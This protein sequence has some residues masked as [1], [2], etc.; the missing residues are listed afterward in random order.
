MRTTKLTLACLL[1]AIAGCECTPGDGEGDGGDGNGSSDGNGGCDGPFRTL[2]GGYCDVLDRCPTAYPIA[3]RSREEC[4]DILCWAFT[5]RL[6]D[7][8][9]NDVHHYRLEQHI[10][11]LTAP[12]AELCATWLQSAPCAVL[13][14]EAD[15]GPNPCSGLTFVADDDDDDDDNGGDIAIG[16]SCEQDNYDCVAGAYCEPGA[17]LEGQGARSCALC[18]AL[19]E[20]GDACGGYG[21]A[22]DLACVYDADA[23]SQVCIVRR[24]A[25]ASCGDGNA[26]TSGFCNFRTN[27]CDDEGLPGDA[28]TERADCRQ[29]FCDGVCRDSLKNGEPCGDQ[30]ECWSGVC[31]ETT[32]R[33]GSPDG[34]QCSYGSQ[35]ESN[36]CDDTTALCAPGAV[37]GASCDYDED[38][39]SGYCAY[40]GDYCAERCS[41]DADCADGERCND[42]P[43]V[44]APLGDDGASCDGDDECTSG[45]CDEYN[46]VCAT[47]PGIGDA[48]TG[49]S[50]CYP[51]GYC[52]NGFCAAREGPGEDCEGYDSCQEPFLCL[53]GKCRLINLKCEPAVAG[54]IC[55]YLRVCDANSF[56]DSGSSFRCRLRVSEGEQCGSSEQCRPDLFCD[57]STG[58]SVCARRV[59][60]GDACTTDDGCR[61]GLFCSDDGSGAFTCNAG[62]LGMPCDEYDAPCPDGLSCVDD[63]CAEPGVAGEACDSYDAPCAEG[64]F[65]VYDECEAP[66]AQGVSCNDYGSVCEDGLYC[67]SSDGCQ[68]APVA[69]E[70]CDYSTPCAPSAWCDTSLYLCK[71]DLAA[72][73]PCSTSYPGQCAAGHFCGYVSEASEYRCRALGA[74]GDDCDDDEECTSGIC[75]YSYGCMATDQCIMP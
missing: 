70:P 66:R 75:D 48:C 35:C 30:S 64:F 21:C 46:E 15:A 10:P 61:D 65:C 12:E 1:V 73:A 14:G 41:S 59:L 56:C 16:A 24:A 27:E 37:L 42:Y 25:G 45:Y 47:K 29:G 52:L 13:D 9:V 50:S 57:Y 32:N 62:P 19:P 31:D 22:G 36:H 67:D 23:G 60:A 2:L 44:C 17:F 11:D 34:A 38:C 26:C 5:C 33:C 39:G 40:P 43:Y 6:E 55:A 69:E 72:D 54:E 74:V 8:E 53:E 63:R 3:Y 7:D 51:L 4:Q 49:Y 28:C 58:S 18:E 20:E 71:A 68:P